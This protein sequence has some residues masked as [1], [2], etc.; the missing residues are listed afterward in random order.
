MPYQLGRRT[1][2]N[3][4]WDQRHLRRAH[5]VG[6]LASSPGTQRL[7]V[8]FV[9]GLIVVCHG[10]RVAPRLLCV[11]RLPP[12]GRAQERGS[13]VSPVDPHFVVAVLN[14]GG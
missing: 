11:F 6:L 8:H 9:V 3:G 14:A 10:L 2:S 4:D 13:G 12:W 7:D 5:D 1:R